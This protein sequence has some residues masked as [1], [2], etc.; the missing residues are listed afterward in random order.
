MTRSARQIRSV[1]GICLAGWETLDEDQLEMC[2]PS[3]QPAHP[4]RSLSFLALSAPSLAKP[5][6][7]YSHL[8]S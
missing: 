7:T 5:K 2:S 6:F 1:S 4:A 8:A 3:A